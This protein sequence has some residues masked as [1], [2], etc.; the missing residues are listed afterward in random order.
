M[1]SLSHLFLGTS[2][3]LY[4]STSIC[5]TP[6]VRVEPGIIVLTVTWVPL[7]NLDKFFANPKFQE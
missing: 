6:S 7:V 5:W 3:L 4:M 2:V 1:K